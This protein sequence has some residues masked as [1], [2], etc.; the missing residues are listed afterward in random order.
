MDKV[1]SYILTQLNDNT[2]NL[3]YKGNYIF[4]FFEDKMTVLE[5][6]T[7]SL[8][9]QELEITP[10]TLL[11]RT[12]VPFT[13]SN[14]RVDWLVQLGFLMRIEGQEY[15]ADDDLDYA[16]LVSVLDALQGETVTID[17]R[18]WSFKTQEP[19]YEGYTML[20]RSK[21]AI[22]TATLNMTEISFGYF[23]QDSTFTVDGDELDVVRVAVGVNKAFYTAGKNS[24]LENDYNKPV[25]R[26]VFLELTFNYNG[27]TDLL[28]EA[29]GK[30]G[31]KDE[32]TLVES[33]A[34]S[35]ATT[36]TYT[37]TVESCQEEIVRGQVKQLTIRFVEV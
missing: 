9:N 30:A 34:T 17:S 8:V 16:N 2:D 37:V 28:D 14:K 29:R 4:K 36:Y 10:V 1:F 7:G 19:N 32:Y 11:S 5:S 15:D 12:P 27:E 20:G 35:P 31:L 24:T 6:V 23:G 33:F 18:K 26:A 13:E 3:T 22:I 25:G 21:Y